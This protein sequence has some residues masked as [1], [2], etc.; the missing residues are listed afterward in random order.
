MTEAA[1]RK[2]AWAIT[3]ITVIFMAVGGFF[4]SGP[5]RW[6]KVRITASERLA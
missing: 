3:A 1:A 2:T 4:V 6:G 5:T